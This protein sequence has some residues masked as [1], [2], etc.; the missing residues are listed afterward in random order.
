MT[1][2]RSFP[3][4]GKSI[5]EVKAKV[6]ATWIPG[7]YE[8][9]IWYRRLKTTAAAEIIM[10]GNTAVTLGLEPHE[11]DEEDSGK[12]EILKDLPLRLFTSV[13]HRYNTWLS[14]GA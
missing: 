13:L 12:S 6:G 2:N 5:N 4:L 9:R 11:F 10:W 7:L 14:F 8:D 1:V 3:N